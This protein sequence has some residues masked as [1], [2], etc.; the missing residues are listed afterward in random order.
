MLSSS[1]PSCGSPL[2]FQHAAAPAVVCG[3]CQA[4]VVR[5]DLD[6][7]VVAGKVA[8]FGRDLSPLQVGVRGEWGG[9]GFEIVGV[10]RKGR[11]AVRWNEW[12]LLFD[13]EGTAWL[14]EGHG[15]FQLFES[16]PS[17]PKGAHFSALRP[18]QQI[19][20]GLG[21]W[22]V[23]EASVAEVVAAE[24]SLPFPV[25]TGQ[26]WPYAD[27][28]APDGRG[29]ATLDWADDE[30]ALWTGRVV[31]LEALEPVGLRALA[32]WSDPVM[33][34][35]EGPEVTATRT[36][37]CPNCSGDLDIRNPGASAHV[38]CEYCG[39]EIALSEL[40]STL[41][42]KVL[43]ASTE[44]R[45]QP[46]IPLGSK[47]E[48]GGHEVQV[49][50]AMRRA[51]SW[52]GQLFPWTELFLYNPY[53][54]TSWLS[55]DQRGHWNHI[56]R[57][58]G[59]PDSDPYRSG[60]VEWRGDVYRHYQGGQAQVLAVL[61]EF[62]WEVRQGDLALT[63]DYVDPPGMIG[64]EK[65]GEEIT[66]TSSRYMTADEVGAAFGVELRSASGMSPN[67]PNPWAGTAPMRK[68][69]VGMGVL[70]ALALL[71]WVF[72]AFVSAGDV[73]LEQTYLFDEAASKVDV[74]GTV[75]VPD[76]M[77]RNLKLSLSGNMPRG[78]AQVHVALINTVSGAVYL[79][80]DTRQ[81]NRTSGWV[82]RPEPGDYVVRVELV[83]NPATS[84]E[85]LRKRSAK[86]EITR[87]APWHLPYV[88]ALFYAM[89]A[90]VLV[91]MMRS[92]FE[93]SR[94]AESDHA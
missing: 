47:G 26:S 81:V 6:E 27:L 36:L 70:A 50:G 94:W 41:S 46:P 88:L 59:F 79:P 63:D 23:L 69:L 56:T 71:F 68:S 7:L 84:S 77:R 93:G 60:R 5:D 76:A 32:G 25:V 16:P 80:L 18:G 17:Y 20:V 57:M 39:S 21:T 14:G 61:G 38:G 86:L 85:V 22:W 55:V 10:L 73:V 62:D 58:V 65:T 40:E 43:S 91:V 30:C 33:V 28:R 67:V 78:E 19:Q 92:R 51:V 75:T 48:L 1:C 3:A 29:V 11:D 66:W 12:F 72:S 90:P 2:V 64:M 44:P 83:P 35:F 31:G 54:G 9:R 42:A 49:I 45:F 15:L 34:A 52:E 89:L 24:G 74:S 87:D 53:R 37:K 8:A 4:T 13:D 82:G